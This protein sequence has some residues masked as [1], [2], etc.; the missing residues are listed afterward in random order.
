MAVS[1]VCL[2]AAALVS[3]LLMMQVKMGADT[4]V[5]VLRNL[6][7]DAP[8]AEQDGRSCRKW[9]SLPRSPHWF[10]TIVCS[11]D[12]FDNNRFQYFFRV[13]RDRADWLVETLYDLL[14]KK[15]TNCR[16]PCSPKLHASLWRLGHAETVAAVGERFGIGPATVQ[17]A[18]VRFC[19]NAG[20]PSSGQG[21][22]RTPRACCPPASH[23]GC[24]ATGNQPSCRSSLS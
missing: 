11:L 5:V 13:T 10:E 12:N 7:F 22:A 1:T 9:V 14:V 2:C 6:L 19:E 8:V 16:E 15:S 3:A 23:E 21:W 18:C 4:S 17:Q 24:S 20:A